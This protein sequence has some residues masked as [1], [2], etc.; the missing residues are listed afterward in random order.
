MD[1]AL[2]QPICSTL[3]QS[4]IARVRKFAQYPTGE[5]SMR[6]LFLAI[7]CTVATVFAHVTRAQELD[8]S[9]VVDMSQLQ[10]DDKVDV[11]TMEADVRTYLNS[12][13]YTREDWEGPRIPVSVNIFLLGRSNNVYTARLT[14]VSQ[15]LVDSEP[16]TGK[17]MFRAYDREWQFQYSFSPSLSFQS[18]RYDDFTSLLD[19]YMLIAIGL[20][21]DTY[22]DLGGERVYADAKQ[23]AQLGNAR[24]ISQFS[25][26][27]QPGEFT[28]MALIT[29]LTDPRY[30][31]FRRLIYD[32]HV[33]TDEFAFDAEAGRKMM[34]KTIK[35]IANFKRNNISN[36]SVLLQAFFDAKSGELA[37]MFRGIKTS[38]IWQELSQLDP[39]NT[40]M[41]EAARQGR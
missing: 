36:R 29:E 20:D 39:G 33:A 7:F 13:R 21:M 31:D 5:R 15:R 4:A 17:P 32:Y 35:D 10:I 27:F 1:C 26:N 22:S 30:Q 9:V 18:M 2:A 3:H 16:G 34:L 41:Y 37:E 11:R 23:I 28:R 25:S 40:Q 24:G 6:T 8:A 38:P 19:F 14:V 12:Q